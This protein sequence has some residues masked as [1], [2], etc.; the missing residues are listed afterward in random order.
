MDTNMAQALKLA[1]GL[2]I[3]LVL[4]SAVVYMF[5]ALA[6][7]QIAL[8]DVKEFE[9]TAEFNKEFEVYN[10]DIMYGLDV[11]SVINKA[12]SYN[13][14]YI[15]AYGYT[16][17][18]KDNYLVDVV[19]RGNGGSANISLQQTLNVTSLQPNPTGKLVENVTNF[20]AL[21]SDS[22]DEIINKLSNKVYIEDTRNLINN[23]K[24]NSTFSD[25]LINNN[26]SLITNTGDYINDDIYNLI[27]APSTKELKAT[28]QN[29][30]TN[31]TTAVELATGANQ[32]YRATFEIYAYSFKSKRFRCTGTTY[33][34]I[35]GRITSLT[36]E[37]I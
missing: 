9:Q 2:L 26:T 4:I 31:G 7:T 27:I 21:N 6:P 35:T 17:D 22:K 24:S 30:D 25:E 14:T 1:G 5:R 16:P 19:L 33:S 32:W 3:A 36:F 28:V 11:I 15:D 8:D 29:T 37:E 20:S 23:L 12:A 18:L 34:D 13:K 10:K